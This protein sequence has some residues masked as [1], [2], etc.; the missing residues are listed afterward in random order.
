MPQLPVTNIPE[1][2]A[3]LLDNFFCEP[4]GVRPRKGFAPWV[5]GLT[6]T[7]ETLFSYAGGTTKKLFAAAGD[8]LYDVTTSGTTPTRLLASLTSAQWNTLNTST[9]GGPQLL[10]FNG[11]DA[12]LRYLVASNTFTPLS[13]TPDGADSAFSPN[14]LVSACQY[15]ARIFMASVGSTTL[16]YTP[17]DTFQGQLGYLECGAAFAQGGTVAAV[18]RWTHDAGNG[19]YD[20]LVVVSTEGDL[21]VYRGTDPSNASAW[22]IAGS[23]RIA[24]PIGRKCLIRLGGDLGLLTV[25]GIKKMSLLIT[26]D[27][28]VNEETDP[29]Y[30]VNPVIRDAALTGAPLVGWSL[31]AHRDKSMMLINVPKVSGAVVEQYVMNIG[32][33]SWSRFTGINAACWASFNGSL[34][35]G[36]TNGRVMQAATGY[37]DNGVP[38]QA[39]MICG[40][41][42]AG[43]QAIIKQGKLMRAIFLSNASLTP[44]VGLCADYSIRLPSVSQSDI[45]HDVAVWD[46]AIWNVSRWASGQFGAP[47]DNW[48]SVNAVGFALAPALSL[49]MATSAPDSAWAKLVGFHVLVEAGGLT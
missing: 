25:D 49:S 20:Q 26:Q 38:I 30:N 29:F 37:S 23:Y 46:R 32:T 14:N 44:K 39:G 4:D 42:A 7:V 27:S 28:G 10:L 31:T 16:R 35:F 48:V 1:D 2:G 15:A 6:G 47:H 41:G 12:P 11:A 17:P 24:K 22:T 34:Y 40:F 18:E 19:L 45:T 8:S 21:V 33:Q 36:M 5:S 9:S 13:F 3:V 43:Q